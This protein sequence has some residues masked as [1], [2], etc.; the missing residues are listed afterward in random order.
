MKPPFSI[1]P[2]EQTP[3]RMIFRT[4]ILMKVGLTR[5]F[6][7]NG[8]DVTL[9]QWG[10]LT[11]LRESDGIHQSALAE[12][13]GKDRHNVT[14]ILNLMAKAGL[15]RRELH[16]E[17][18]RCQRVF[19]TDKGIAVQAVMLPIVVDFFGKAFEG[20]SQEDLQ[21]LTRILVHITGNLASS[22]SA[23]TE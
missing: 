3:G 7:D 8:F 17:D 5:A 19:L 20:L 16:P 4:A 9:E 1:H 10:L 2:R 15:V 6:Q 18:K 11:S 14:R 12:R 23:R 21:E 22:H 13:T